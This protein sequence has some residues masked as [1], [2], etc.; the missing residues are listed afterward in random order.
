MLRNGSRDDGAQ[1][2]PVCVELCF[3]VSDAPRLRLTR[4]LLVPQQGVDALFMQFV[5]VWH[6]RSW[7]IKN[8]EMKHSQIECDS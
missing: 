4:C 1:P 3:Q 8:L 7:K 6:F 5:S 2:P